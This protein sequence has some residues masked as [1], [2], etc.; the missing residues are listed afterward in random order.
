MKLFL[1][2]ILATLLTGCAGL[3]VNWDLTA[4]YRSEVPVGGRK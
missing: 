3:S 2:L 1:S 4:T